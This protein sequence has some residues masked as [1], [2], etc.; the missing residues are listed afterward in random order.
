VLLE[1]NSRGGSRSMHAL[2]VGDR[3]TV[4]SPRNLFPL[5][6]EA[7]HSVLIGGG[8]GITPLLAMARHLDAAGASFELHYCVRSPERM[9]FRHDLMAG[10]FADHV[11]LYCDTDPAPDRFDAGRVLVSPEPGK[12]MY[13]CGPA[14][15]MAAVL[16]A[17][18]ERGWDP[19]HVH[20][21]YFGA[22]PDQ[23]SGGQAFTIRLAR[24]GAHVE[25]GAGETISRRSPAPASRSTR[26]ASKAC[27]APV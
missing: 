11:R 4:G 19:A 8:I 21:E 1:P 16:A 10:R 20:R 12:H 6:D 15:F 14:G 17:A 18:S 24:R 2:S 9:A 5:A 22:A 23:G 27:A 7:R 25:V 3:L 13:V 26:P